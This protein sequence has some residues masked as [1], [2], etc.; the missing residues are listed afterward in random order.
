[1]ALPNLSGTATGATIG[2][3]LLPVWGTVI[4]A[5]LGAIFDTLSW[6]GGQ[7]SQDNADLLQ[8]KSDALGYRTAVLE[9]QT[10]IDQTKSDISAYESFLS[11][12]PNYAD[13]QKNA[14]EAESRSEFKGLLENFGAS[15]VVAGITGRSGGSAGLVSK[16]MENELDDFAGSDKVLGGE[17]GRYAMARTELLGNLATEESQAR[18]QLSVLTSSLSTLDETLGLYNDAATSA[19]ARVKDETKAA[20]TWWNPFD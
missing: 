3:T 15:N 13:L 14:F 17:G 16:Q 8:A 10:S 4:G 11:A 6:L 7:N 5:G 2:T 1:M 20:S 19:D 18:N 9:T 12:F